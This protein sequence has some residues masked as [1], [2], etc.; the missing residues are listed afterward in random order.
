MQI[1]NTP[2][3]REAVINGAVRHHGRTSRRTHRR[4]GG[5][6]MIT[7]LLSIENMSQEIRGRL[8]WLDYL[9]PGEMNKI[10]EAELLKAALQYINVL[11]PVVEKYIDGTPKDEAILFASLGVD[12]E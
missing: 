2:E 5:A 8:D 4:S 11:G 7:K 9:R 12:C 3:E 10:E 1:Q 6:L